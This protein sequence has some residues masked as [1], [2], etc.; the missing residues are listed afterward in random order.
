M[1]LKQSSTLFSVILKIRFHNYIQ[2]FKILLELW[3]QDFNNFTATEF[4]INYVNNDW[5]ETFIKR[6][7][8]KARKNKNRPRYVLKLW[9]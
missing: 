7:I 4:G 1:K 3:N 8:D 9:L 6:K 2:Y 5:T